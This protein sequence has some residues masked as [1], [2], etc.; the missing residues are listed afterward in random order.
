M[1][2]NAIRCVGKYLYDNG[3]VPKET[4]TIETPGGIRELKLYIM[5]SAVSSVEVNMGKA[6][7]RP[8]DVPVKLDGDSILSRRVNIV[9]GEYDIT[10]VSVGNPHCV[11]FCDRVDNVDVAKLGPMFENAGI[12]PE[13]V[14]TEFVRLVNK[15][16]LKMRVWERGNGETA[17]C[18]TGACAAVIAA[19]E[20]GYCNKGEDITVKLKGGDLIVNYSDDA[21]LLTGSTALI[22]EGVIQY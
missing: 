7:L 1:A 13:G 21:V 11:V 4:M 8:E 19:V 22:Y 2:G 12:F 3:I 9:G 20:N 5:N 6:S 18:G 15:N 14:N 17:A 10:C 16:T